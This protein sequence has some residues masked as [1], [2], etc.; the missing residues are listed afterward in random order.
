M[1]SSR[2]MKARSSLLAIFGCFIVVG[3]MRGAAG[4]CSDPIDA[5]A[6]V[7]VGDRLFR[8]TR[9]AQFFFNF[10]TAAPNRDVNTTLK[11]GDPTVSV[12]QNAAGKPIRDPFRNQ[13]M[14]CRNCHLGDDLLGVSKLEGRTYC[15]FARRSPIPARSD[16]PL[17]TTRNA[18]LLVSVSIPREVPF[19][20][21]FDG[22]FASIE[23]LALS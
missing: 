5:P 11:P 12:E 22:E 17:T 10:I 15:D 9:F 20:F 7:Q 8:E 2:S 16:G 23:D 1:S 6:A 3:I 21:H 4:A 18:P 19:L 13:S 14:N